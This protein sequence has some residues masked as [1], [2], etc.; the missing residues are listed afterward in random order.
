MAGLDS[1]E[2]VP[3][4]PAQ[5]E[6]ILARAEKAGVTVSTEGSVTMLDDPWGT[7]IVLAA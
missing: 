4:D 3:R 7:H 5:R 1:V 2:I 6:A